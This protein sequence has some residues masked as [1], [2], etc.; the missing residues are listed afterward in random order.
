MRDEKKHHILNGD[1]IYES[2]TKDFLNDPRPLS[3]LAPE[4]GISNRTL[5]R[6]IHKIGEPDLYTLAKIN[7]WLNKRG[8]ENEKQL[9]Q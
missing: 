9:L 4:I 5:H 3:M 2:F 8:K 7:N 1:A 6:F